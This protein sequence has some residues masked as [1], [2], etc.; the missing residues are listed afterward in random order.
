M[1]STTLASHRFRLRVATAFRS[2]LWMAAVSRNGGI[3]PFAARRSSRRGRPARMPTGRARM[4]VRRRPWSADWCQ[5]RQIGHLRLCTALAPGG[6]ARFGLLGTHAQSRTASCTRSTGRI[7]H[8]SCD[9]LVTIGAARHLRGDFS[10]FMGIPLLVWH[11]LAPFG[12]AAGGRSSS[13]CEAWSRRAAVRRGMGDSRP[14]ARR[15]GG[16]P[17]GDSRA[18]R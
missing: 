6:K 7:G 1:T 18:C 13:G 17:R 5:A 12:G 8:K 11:P 9:N 4:C 15:A 16:L 2:R 10:C 14:G 3:H